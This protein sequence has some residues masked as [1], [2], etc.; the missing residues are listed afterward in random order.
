MIECLGGLV[1]ITRN[2]CECWEVTEEQQAK[3][4]PEGACQ[5]LDSWLDLNL[6]KNQKCIDTIDFACQLLAD[7]EHEVY[8]EIQSQLLHKYNTRDT[9]K[10]KIGKDTAKNKGTKKGWKG[11]RVTP[12]PTN[13][14]FLCVQRFAI[15]TNETVD[16]K[17]INEKGELI[18]EFEY[19]GNGTK[20]N[21][22]D[23]E[24]TAPT[25]EC[26]YFLHN[27]CTY[28]DN[29]VSCNCSSVEEIKKCT[30]VEGVCGEITEGECY[31]FDLET[32]SKNAYGISM[33]VECKCIMD[34]C[35][36]LKH[37]NVVNQVAKM[38]AYKAGELG[39]RKALR[40][41]KPCVHIG[42]NVE[43]EISKYIESY[44]WFVQN[45]CKNIHLDKDCFSCKGPNFRRR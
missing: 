10:G 8:C 21:Y 12:R 37:P 3:L 25:S 42:E 9:L 32:D 30:H 28:Y 4:N 34:I 16:V 33:H 24:I 14:R 5:Y 35:N 40:S 41:S 20:F 11:I 23:V 7:A 36:A 1:G 31:T 27:A 13:D 2:V 39:Y 45:I 19:T 44:D 22:V 6:L 15:A 18:K 43:Q 29:K 38:I 17:V 26:Y